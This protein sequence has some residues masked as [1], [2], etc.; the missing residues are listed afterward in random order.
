MFATTASDM[1]FMISYWHSRMTHKTKAHV[2]IV[3]P[4][5]ILWHIWTERNNVIHRGT[6][7]NADIVIDRINLYLQWGTSAKTIEKT[8]WTECTP[9]IR[10]KFPEE[11]ESG[12]KTPTGGGWII[13]DERGF[14][15]GG[16]AMSTRV[17]SK[18]EAGLKVICKG[19]EMAKQWGERF[20]SGQT[21]KRLLT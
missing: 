5:L 15:L 17:I 11:G 20:G 16:F 4:C 13:R 18:L 10:V 12:A 3:I 9:Q 7:F 6:T 19:V 2:R 8:Q 14:I 1:D 21:H